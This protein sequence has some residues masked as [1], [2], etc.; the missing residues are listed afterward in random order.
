MPLTQR[1]LNHPGNKYG[2]HHKPV[3]NFLATLFVVARNVGIIGRYPFRADAKYLRD[4]AVE[5]P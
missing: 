5:L 4:D 2:S 1:A 3:A